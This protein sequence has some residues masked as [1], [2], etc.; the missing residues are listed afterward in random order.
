MR[1]HNKRPV[2]GPHGTARADGAKT[3]APGRGLRLQEGALEPGPPEALECLGRRRIVRHQLEGFLVRLDGCLRLVLEVCTPPEVLLTELVVARSQSL[4]AAVLHGPGHLLLE[5]G[6]LR[7]PRM[8]GHT[9]DLEVVL[10][11]VGEL[12]DVIRR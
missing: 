8:A 9:G 7:A 5:R 11:T 10:P 2:S 4:Q 1:T 6:G 3:G 12:A